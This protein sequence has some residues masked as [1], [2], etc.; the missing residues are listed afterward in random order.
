MRFLVSCELEGHEDDTL[1]GVEFSGSL[2]QEDLALVQEW[3][4]QPEACDP[5]SLRAIYGSKEHPV[6][7]WL[8]KWHAVVGTTSIVET[9]R[10]QMELPWMQSPRG[11]PPAIEAALGPLRDFQIGAEKAAME[12]AKRARA[13]MHKRFVKCV[14]L[15]KECSNTL[16]TEYVADMSRWDC[17][18]SLV[19]SAVV[20]FSWCVGKRAERPR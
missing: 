11:D 3:Q 19:S 16:A 7:P 17:A 5:F 1:P 4:R 14:F 15:G 13:T 6:K 9:Q 8:L 12:S 2:S 18:P 20:A 10:V